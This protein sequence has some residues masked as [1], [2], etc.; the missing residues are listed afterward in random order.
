MKEEADDGKMGRKRNIGKTRSIDG[1]NG[2][3]KEGEE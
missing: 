1:G 2:L 3:Q